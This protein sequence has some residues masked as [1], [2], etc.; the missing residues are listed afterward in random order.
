MSENIGHSFVFITC[1][2]NH[3]D[4]AIDEIRSIPIVTSV[5][6]VQGLYD[7]MV[8]L[9]APTEKMK[10]TIRTKIRYVYGVRSVLTLFE[11]VHYR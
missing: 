5:H 11:Y 9:K 10:A 7:I 6:R 4:S 2:D 1:D 3:V 8:Q